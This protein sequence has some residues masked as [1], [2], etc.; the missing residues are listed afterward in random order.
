LNI[1]PHC[2]VLQ[3]PRQCSSNTQKRGGSGVGSPVAYTDLIYYVI[4]PYKIMPLSSMHFTDAS[5][6]FVSLVLYSF[7]LLLG[8]KDGGKLGL[9]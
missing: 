9:L 7:L 1:P 8:N 2:G 5:F 6:S 4:P 3:S